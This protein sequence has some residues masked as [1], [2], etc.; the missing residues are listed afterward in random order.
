MASVQISLKGLRVF[1][2][3]VKKDFANN[4]VTPIKTAVLKS[5]LRGKSPVKGKRWQKYSDSYKAQIKGTLDF[6]TIK[7]RV[8]PMKPSSAG[9]FPQQFG[10][11]I[12]P[13]NMKLTGIM[14]KSFF[15]KAKGLSLLQ[16]FHLELGFKDPVALFHDVKGAGKSKVIRRL[17]PHTG[18][19]FNKKITDQI[20]F[21]LRKSVRKTVLKINS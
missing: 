9:T 5:I 16:G 19:K 15:V 3:A 7:G 4:A 2:P 1:V 17:L 20:L 21:Q 11:K 18:E 6:R 12:S 14:L 10:K 13:R 8:V